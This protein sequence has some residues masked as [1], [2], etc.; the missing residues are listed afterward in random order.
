MRVMHRRM[1]ITAVA[2]VSL[3]LTGATV[4][5]PEK[6]DID[7][8]H[9]YVGFNVKHLGVSN[10]KGKFNEFSGSIMLDPVDITKS[11][12]NVSV[13]AASID[14]NNER[15]DADL[16]SANFF[17]VE[18][19]PTL[20]FV[21]KRVEKTADGMV[22]IGDLTI[23]DVTKEVRIP[24]ELTGPLAGANGRKRMGAEGTLKINRFDY[25]LKWNRLQETVAVV[26]EEVRIELNIE[27]NTPRPAGAG[28]E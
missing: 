24:F 11:T 6:F 26:S 22:V 19:F 23:R 17:E 21:G 28:N 15:R 13:N 16:K 4:R 25:G 3:S 8:G 5:A 20:T 27:A 14:T 7:M 18:K 2:T 12:V 1:L 9:S 10:V